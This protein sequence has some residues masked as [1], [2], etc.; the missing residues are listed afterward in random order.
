MTNPWR[1]ELAVLDIGEVVEDGTDV[2]VATFI[3]TPESIAAWEE[4]VTV[5]NAEARAWQQ[6]RSA[7]I[8][9]FSADCCRGGIAQAGAD[10]DGEWWVCQTCGKRHLLD[11]AT[12]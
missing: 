5:L 6:L 4:R 11:Y 3:P 1:C 7:A 8:A 10:S 9:K 2:I 12:L